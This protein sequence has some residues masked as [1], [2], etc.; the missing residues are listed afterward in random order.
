MITYCMYVRFENRNTRTEEGT[1]KFLILSVDGS[2]LPY[3]RY[4]NRNQLVAQSRAECLCIGVQM[5][6]HPDL[7]PLIRM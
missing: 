4:P 2:K 3:R 5:G 1:I 6:W 7:H